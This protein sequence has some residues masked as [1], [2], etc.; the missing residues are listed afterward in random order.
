MDFV[1]PSVR[2]V[3]SVLDLTGVVLYGMIGATIA[4]ARNFDFVGIIFLA[5]ITALGGG[6]VRDVLIDSGPPAALQDMRYFGLAL[7]GAALATAIHM[8]SRWWELFRVHGDAVVLGVWA[9]TGSSKALANGLPWSSAL[10]LGVL[11]VVGGGMIRDVMTG[12]VP[13]IFGGATLYATPAA[14][15]AALM[16]GIWSFNESGVSGDVPVLFIGMIVAPVLGAGM[17]ILSYWRGWKLPGTQDL[18]WAAQRKLQRPMT[19]ARD[20]ARRRGRMRRK[21]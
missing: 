5:I 16:V 18:S 9:A 1:D 19:L 2:T 6:M 21:K 13:E 10:F 8:N 15:T 17:M 11:T 7:I 12:S 4:R 14:L 20:M 3:Y